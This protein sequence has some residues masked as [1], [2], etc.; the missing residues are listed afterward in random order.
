[1]NLVKSG[2]SEL[3]NGLEAT[4][5]RI[6]VMNMRAETEITLIQLMLS[7]FMPSPASRTTAA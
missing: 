5:V 6:E 3:V 7:M 2:V 1:M 4:L